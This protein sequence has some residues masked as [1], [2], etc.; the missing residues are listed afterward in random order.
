MR[1]AGGTR[2][3]EIAAPREKKNK[4]RGLGGGDARVGGSFAG[5][6]QYNKGSNTAP[7]QSSTVPR[8]GRV[9]HSY[10]SPVKPTNTRR[11]ALH[12]RPRPVLQESHHVITRFAGDT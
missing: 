12:E 7:N 11:S 1:K 5:P 4:E 2:L 8:R 10:P 9:C 3:V 6:V